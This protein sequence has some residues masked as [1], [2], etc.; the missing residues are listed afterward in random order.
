MFY[1]PWQGNGVTLDSLLA[2]VDSNLPDIKEGQMNIHVSSYATTG[3]N[4]RQVA[5]LRCL[6]VKSELITRGGLDES[7]FLTDKVV[8]GPYDGRQDVVVVAVKTL[9]A[10]KPKP[11]PE[12]EQPSTD[13]QPLVQQH[14]QELETASRPLTYII[15]LTTTV[16]TY[17]N[18]HALFLRTNLLRWATLTPDLGVE[19]QINSKI[20]ILLSGSWT[21]WSWGDKNR[22]YAL[23]RV[24]PALHYYIGKKKRGYIGAM[25]H[26]GEFNNKF[27]PEGEQGNYQGGGITGGYQLKLNHTLSIDFNLGVGYTHANYDSYSV[28]DN[29]QVHTGKGIR[30]HWGINQLGTTL[31]WKIVK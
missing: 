29:V 3:T 26:I 2:I 25:Y 21:S 1:I 20:G 16:A 12:L 27:K 8:I 5:Y 19:W 22:R 11:E 9:T 6:R 15:P 28:V 10:Q 13:P 30:E 31:R 17:H 18:E 7:N 24:S 14:K 4:A 23:W